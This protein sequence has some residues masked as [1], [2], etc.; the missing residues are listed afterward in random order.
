MTTK[1]KPEAKKCD[2]KATTRKPATIVG[3]CFHT[4]NKS[5]EVEQQGRIV[6]RL[7]DGTHL[8]TIYSWVDGKALHHKVMTF[9]DIRALELYETDKQMR[10]RYSEISGMSDE[11]FEASE[12]FLGFLKKT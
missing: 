8:V 6:K 4:K 7:D 9:K 11:E 2:K 5:G 3:M 10:R 1:S 12:E